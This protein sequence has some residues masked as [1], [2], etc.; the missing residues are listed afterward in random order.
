MISKCMTFS[1]FAC[2]MAV[3][4]L[5]EMPRLAHAEG[6]SPERK[7]ES[8][9]AQEGTI[10]VTVRPLE[11]GPE[12]F[13]FGVALT[14]DQD[15][16]AVSLVPRNG[17]KIDSARV[18]SRGDVIVCRVSGFPWADPANPAP[19][20]EQSEKIG[21]SWIFRA[22]GME[23][24]DDHSVDF[25]GN[26][27][28]VRKTGSGA[29]A[30]GPAE[31]NTAVADIQMDVGGSGFG[32]LLGG[33]SLFASDGGGVALP[34]CASIADAAA[35]PTT[36]DLDDQ[37]NPTDKT[38]NVC[39]MSLNLNLRLPPSV[40]WDEIVGSLQFTFLADGANEIGVYDV[41]SERKTATRVTSLK[42]VYA[43]GLH[44]KRYLL[45]AN[46]NFVQPNTLT[47][48]FIWAD[49]YSP[50]AVSSGRVGINA[51]GKFYPSLAPAQ[52]HYYYGSP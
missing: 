36:L 15:D 21:N 20:K 25:A 8:N 38:L 50:G 22:F 1:F 9:L 27:V 47:C 44:R 6:D 24:F 17:F 12:G 4:S 11:N 35:F 43:G 28:R 23:P 7:P 30:N 10:F 31:F 26:L 39:A 32:S 46:K 41:H 40:G 52:G 18:L 48:T 14:V 37:L 51:S 33:R 34:A 5:T 49:K 42:E 45:L 29:A 13:G 19:P 3:L 16:L 2:S